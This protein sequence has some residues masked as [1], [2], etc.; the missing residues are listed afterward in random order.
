MKPA[1]KIGIIY[2][3][4]GSLWILSSDK[5]L[6]GI[7]SDNMFQERIQ[8]YKG[9][10]FV[11]VTGSLLIY[12]IQKETKRRNAIEKKLKE[13]ICYAEQN[14]RLKTAFL[15]NMSH[16]IRTPMNGILGFAELLKNNSLTAETRREYLDIIG[17]QGKQLLRIIM[18]IIDLAKIESGELVMQPRVFSLVE[19]MQKTYVFFKELKDKEGRG[20]IE[21]K[22]NL[23][24]NH[25]VDYVVADPVR[26]EQILTNLLSNALKFTEKGF[27]EL[28]YTK[29]N[30]Q[31]IQFYVKDSGIG[32]KDDD[33]DLIFERFRQIDA[34]TEGYHDGTGLGLTI[35][36][37]LVKLMEGKIWVESEY[38]KGSIFHFTIPYKEGLPQMKKKE[39]YALNE[40]NWSKKVI[41][42]AE[43][44]VFNYQYLESVLVN[45]KA[46]LVWVKN[47]QE[48]VNYVKSGK[49]ADA[50]LMDIRMPIMD[51]YT[52]T[53]EIKK[54][55]KFLTVIAQTAFAMTMEKEE[56]ENAGCD[57]YLAKPI[58]PRILLEV[59]QKHFN[60]KYQRESN[61]K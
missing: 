10:F 57:D 47:G 23:S 40:Y 9:W 6:S 42:I 36:K 20:D 17:M 5:L 1:F 60:K 15:S 48:A 3:I 29:P 27:I 7:S 32:I 52:A 14:D 50:V 33:K 59:L 2:I 18:D 53:K 19:L 49:H 39:E 30:N 28:G 34:I 35:S 11:L 25:Q 41:L 45:T 21:L 58:R 54:I 26:I 55:N 38:Q 16:E 13:A 8:T 24:D 37:G 22:L 31:W 12:L 56:C 4:V 51:G 43:D 44:E 46:R 61:V